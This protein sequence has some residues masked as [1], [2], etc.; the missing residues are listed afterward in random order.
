MTEVVIINTLLLPGGVCRLIVA[1]NA[2]G[3]LVA[4]ASPVEV[5]LGE[6]GVGFSTKELVGEVLDMEIFLEADDFVSLSVIDTRL[7][8][9]RK[10]FK[11]FPLLL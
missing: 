4:A 2:Q 7:Q 3:F 6:L 11:F 1:E 5:S 8:K 9:H 10:Q